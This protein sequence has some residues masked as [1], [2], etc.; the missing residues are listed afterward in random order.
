MTGAMA[1]SH[2]INETARIEA[3]SDGVFAI[4]ITL[5]ILEISVPVLSGDDRLAD[6]L[7]DEWASYFAYVLSF[8]TI[9]IYWANHHSFF[10]LFH[11]VDHGFLMLNVFFLMTIAFL[12]FPT[13]VL[14]EYLQD[15][16]ERQ[17]AVAFYAFGLAL[18]AFGWL[19]LWAWANLRDLVVH[20]LDE[21]YRRV[22]T[23]QYV[24]SNMLY[25]LAF[26]LAFVN[27]WLALALC[28]GL[29][30]LYVLPP[31]RPRFVD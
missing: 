12:P 13:A 6:A 26:G 18:P 23:R 15:E 4:A 20:D 16:G 19:L 25:A 14:A 21:G 8:I 5:L 29:T 17:T 22:A 27:E 28:T 10:K 9:G 7:V 30:A 24:A 2:E 11:H 31:R 3:F 1:D